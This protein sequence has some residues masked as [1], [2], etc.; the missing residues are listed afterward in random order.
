[1]VAGVGSGNPGHC[2]DED[3]CATAGEG[4]HRLT[5]TPSAS[6]SRLANMPAFRVTARERC[7]VISPTHPAGHALLSISPDVLCSS[8]HRLSALQH[9]N[10][11]AISLKWT[12]PILHT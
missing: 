8:N 2:L 6:N 4:L 10:S 11:E 12:K 3:A 7:H 9:R 1:M 5:T